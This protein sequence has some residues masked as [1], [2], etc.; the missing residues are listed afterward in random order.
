MIDTHKKGGLRGA[1]P[2]GFAYFHVE[3]TGAS[4]AHLVED[5]DGFKRDFG[6]GVVAGMLGLDPRATAGG[7][8]GAAPAPATPRRSRT[9]C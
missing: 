2:E 8:E 1:V 6:V 9:K 5:G 3:W 7:E 4:Y